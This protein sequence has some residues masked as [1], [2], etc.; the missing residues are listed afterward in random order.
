MLRLG[1]K[2]E[3]ECGRVGK[4]A[5]KVKGAGLWSGGAAARWQSLNGLHVEASLWN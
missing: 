3:N 1:E 2:R 4:A 5:A